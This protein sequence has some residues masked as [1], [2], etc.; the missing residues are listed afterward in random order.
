ME[1]TA[2]AHRSLIDLMDSARAAIY[3]RLSP[4]AQLVAQ[5]YGVVAPE[6]MGVARIC[7]LLSHAK[8]GPPNPSSNPQRVRHCNAELIKHGIAARQRNLGVRA[9]PEWELPLTR[10]AHQAGNLN[11]LMTAIRQEAPSFEYDAGSFMRELRCNLVAGDLSLLA[12]RFHGFNPPAGCWRFLAEPPATDLINTL[13]WPLRGQALMGCL[14]HVIETAAPAEALLEASV[15]G[16][17]TTYGLLGEFAF[18]RILQGRFD[19]AEAAFTALPSNSRAAKPA[20]TGLASTR[21]LIAL[22]CKDDDA[23]LRHIEE[24]LAIERAGTRKRLLFPDFRAFALSLLS[25]VRM[26]TGDSHDLL[27][28]IF[29]GAERAGTNWSTELQFV[30]AARMIKSGKRVYQMQQPPE[31]GIDVLMNGL[32]CCWMD[33]FSVNIPEWT[34][35][36]E[37]Y[38]SRASANGFDWVAAE[39][40]ELLRRFAHSSGGGGEPLPQQRNG[41]E[42]NHQLLE[43]ATLA[44]LAVPPPEWEISLKAIERIAERA[45]SDAQKSGKSG[46]AGRRLVWILVDEGYEFRAYPKAQQRK[47]NGGWT[48]G[49][50]VAIQRLAQGAESMD[51]LSPQDLQAASTI[52]AGDRWGAGPAGVNEAGIFALAGHPH[53]FGEHGQ[54][55]EIVRREPELRITE[56]EGGGAVVTMRPYAQDYG[57]SFGL[58]LTRMVTD[59]RC[60]AT[61]FAKSH[62]RLLEI[63][64]E[65]GLELP[66]E[67]RPRLLAAV[68]SLAAGVR[69]QSDAVEA[70]A[71]ASSVESDPAP[72]V[73]LEPFGNGLSIA[74]M[75]EAIR[76]SEL[77]FAP[78]AGPVTVFASRGG[79]SVQAVRDFAAERAAMDGLAR[80]CPMLAPRPTELDPLML[81]EPAECLELL[82]SL[83][84]ASVRCQWPKGQ[85]MRIVASAS[86][87]SLA[88][89]IKSAG[90]WLQASGRLAVDKER[91]LDLKQLLKALEE[92]PG[93]RFVAVGAGEFVALTRTFRRQLDDLAG[94]STPAAGGAVRLHS[95]AALA[96][97]DVIENASLTAD[98]GWR[99]LR[100]RMEKANSIEPEL[101][102][103]LRAELRPYQIEG[104]RWLARLARWG[105]GACLADDMG[106]G[107]TVQ[108]LALLLSRAPEGSAL[109]V[110]PTSVAANWID[111]ARRFAPT[112][113]VTEYAGPAERREQLLTAPGPFDLVVATYGLLQNDLDRL[114]AIHWR[115]VVLDEAQAIKNAATKRARAA[116][117]LKADFRMVTTGTPIQNSLMDLHS[118][119]RF[120]NPGL[121]GSERWFRRNF[122]AAGIHDGQAGDSSRLRRL[123]R[124][125]MLRRLKADVLDDLPERTEIT[126][127]VRMS[128]EEASLY[129]ALRQ[130]AIEDLEAPRAD[131]SGAGEA[132]RRVQALAHLTRL[133][134][135]CCHTGLVLN[136]HG[137][138]KEPLPAS[139]KLE[140][141]AGI[142]GELIRNGHKVLVFS[143]FV[144]HLKLVEEY[145]A[146]AG[147]SYQYLDGSTPRKARAERINAFQSGAGDVFLISLKAGGLGLN[148]TAADY[149]I[150]LD[151]WWNPAVED[152]ASD[153]AH[154]I[155]Q[156][157]PVTIYRLVTEG[158]I[159]QQIV[160]LHKKKRELADHMLEGAGSAGKLSADELLA[161]LRHQMDGA[162]G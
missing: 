56:N 17:E 35:A 161:L 115:T 2:G 78:A 63:I 47:K 51:F 67:V 38:Q 81:P 156:K 75:V 91:A 24:A 69:V 37:H 20:G 13:S 10:A 92:S 5:V 29:R 45:G 82:E 9:L 121:L 135:A 6:P 100:A 95:L 43:T 7:S 85:P 58:Y 93:S 125:F 106:L 122:G 154:R 112:L 40:N 52:P 104:Y 151:P 126:L 74:V 158:T 26:D 60:E 129:E 110:A 149:V 53:V 127:R 150:H 132:V 90:E 1:P 124:P 136:T 80:Q 107:K 142:L 143:Q 133:R 113:N 16:G 88:L 31:L 70:K 11:R 4:A 61:R 99:E 25:L 140:T 28:R 119:F 98:E 72:C 83:E 148:L 46:P 18:A 118:L 101:P 114:G 86:A 48:R 116:R 23:A 50:K 15:A 33:D 109:V 111:Q 77:F 44:S 141:F 97:D 68:S 139:S 62:L 146:G 59:R 36:L 39:C 155:G 130:R 131:A 108:T 117:R 12:K 41:G 134:L 152:Q 138:D 102:G 65:E 79:E 103:T 159:E 87:P 8:T 49:R 34:D 66:A 147:V 30:S 89:N 76:G 54:P 14:S 96:L 27:D 128:S 94:L 153:R 123:V 22:L 21:A 160:E 71:A 32:M 157:R 55:I 73:R 162:N 84:A 120:L 19:S 57:D 3:E 144:R 145:V 137:G 42:S 105:A 64:P